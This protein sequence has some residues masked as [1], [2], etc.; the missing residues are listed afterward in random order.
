MPGAC[1][2]E[3]SNETAAAATKRIR[4]AAQPKNATFKEVMMNRAVSSKVKG[5]PLAIRTTAKSKLLKPML[6]RWQLYVMVLP[7]L[8]FIIL[9]AYKPM[10]GIL[11]AFKNF[12][13]R[14]GI[15]GS[16]WVGLDNF[17][18]LFNSYWFPIIIKNTLSISLLSL[19]VG[20][21]APIILALMVNEIK[22]ERIKRTF[23]TVSYAPHF[24]STVVMCGMITLFLSPTSGIVNK[25]L[26]AIGLA[27]V[28]FMQEAGLF[29]WIYVISG[30][31]QGVGWGAIIYF[32]ALS[33]VDKALLEAADIDGAS[34]LQK[35]FYINLPVLVPT[36]V[37]L[38]ILQCGSLL[39]VG[40]EKVY[41]LQ[42]ATNI[43][44]SEVISTYVYKVGLI[45]NDFSFSTAAGLFNSV[46]NAAILILAN[47]LSR[48]IGKV[49]LW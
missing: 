26:N 5:S 48:H 42:N 20:F 44:A 27:S 34:R 11:I 9:F 7:A 24:I 31:W 39:S 36:I 17:I 8:L 4:Q 47:T 2:H 46:V 29:K 23:Q 28:F 18:R 14:K 22:S 33:G 19:L 37:V 3:L 43:S 40:Y 10:Y 1:Y 32:A 35:I 49:G 38:F 25:G 12:S 15:M 21:P 30:I 45:N 41:L 6:E 13:M 16:D